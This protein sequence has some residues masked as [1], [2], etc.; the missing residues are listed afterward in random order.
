MEPV[1]EDGSR[2][3]PYG[4]WVFLRSFFDRSVL[5]PR[6]AALHSLLAQA[7][8]PAHAL[9]GDRVQSVFCRLSY[10]LCHSPG[11]RNC[12]EAENNWRL[13]AGRTGQPHMDWVL[14]C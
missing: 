9:L 10:G 12:G 13:R 4:A 7:T 3:R 11:P 5:E 2:S 6:L 1:D 8:V 14:C